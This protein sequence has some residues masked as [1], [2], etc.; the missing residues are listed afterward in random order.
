MSTPVIQFA[1]FVVTTQVFYVSKLSAALVNLKPILPGHSLV[2]PRRNVP[3][4]TD[5]SSEEVADLFLREAAIEGLSNGQCP[6]SG[7]SIGKRV[8]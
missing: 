5:L 3:R 7:K 1:Q 4:Y 8:S 2:I 6:K